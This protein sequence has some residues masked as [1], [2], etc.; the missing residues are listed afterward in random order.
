MSVRENK[1]RSFSSHL[2][3]NLPNIKRQKRSA[4]SKHRIKLIAVEMLGFL[5]INCF[6]IQTFVTKSTHTHTKSFLIFICW[7]AEH[8][9]LASVL[10]H[11][12]LVFLYRL[13][14]ASALF[15]FSCHKFYV[16]A[17]LGSFSF[18]IFMLLFADISRKCTI[19]AKMGGKK[20][21]L[22]NFFSLS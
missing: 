8:L 9:C 7:A 4:D 19:P 13:L 17:G 3:T 18:S 11:F 14:H 21:L 10:L 16:L 22:K 15:F 12:S 20:N 2:H 5:F 6:Y 1:R